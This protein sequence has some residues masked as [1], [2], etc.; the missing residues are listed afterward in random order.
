MTCMVVQVGGLVAKEKKISFCV[1]TGL[2]RALL[3]A[4]K[5][6]CDTDPY[7]MLLLCS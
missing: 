1:F 7:K 5:Y 6:K 3:L 2:F 4:D